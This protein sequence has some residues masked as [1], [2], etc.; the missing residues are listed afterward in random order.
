[1]NDNRGRRFPLLSLYQRSVSARA[2]GTSYAS[3]VEPDKEVGLRKY[4]MPP[5]EL[6]KVASMED[7][8]RIVGKGFRMLKP[9]VTPEYLTL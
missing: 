2:C 7:R 4:Q 5:V 9:N 8:N 1:M 6:L 3:I